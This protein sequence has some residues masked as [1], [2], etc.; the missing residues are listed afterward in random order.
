[1]R[2]I[3]SLVLALALLCSASLAL[4]EA[5]AFCSA[6]K[7]WSQATDLNANDYV[8]TFYASGKPVSR[9]TLRGADGIR[10]IKL[11]NAGQG[12]DAEFTETAIIQYSEKGITIQAQDKVIVVDVNSILNW[13]RC[14]SKYTPEM[15]KED[16]KLVRD[17]AVKAAM[18]LLQPTMTVNPETSALQLRIDVTEKEL[19]ERFP[20]FLDSLTADEA[21]VNALLM[22]YSGLVCS[23]FPSCPLTLD[24]LKALWQ[25]Y[26]ENPDWVMPAIRL[27]AD[28]AV[29]PASE[30]GKL[31]IGL[32]GNLSVT[33][34]QIS[35]SMEYLPGKNLGY[36]LSGNVN[37]TVK[38]KP[39]DVDLFAQKKDNQ[40]QA[41]L[42]VLGTEQVIYGVDANWTESS[43]SVTMSQQIGTQRKY[44][45]L[46]GYYDKA[47]GDLNGTVTYSAYDDA[48]P[49]EEAVYMDLVQLTATVQ[50]QGIMGTAIFPQNRSVRFTLTNGKLYYRGQFLYTDETGNTQVDAW[51]F[52]QGNKT[53]RYRVEALKDAKRYLISGTASRDHFDLTAAPVLQDPVLTLSVDHAPAEDHHGVTASLCLA[54]PGKSINFSG[55][56]KVDAQKCPIFVDA[57]LTTEGNNNIFPSGVYKLSYV[58]GQLTYIDNSNFYE[59]IRTEDTQ[60]KL[61]YVLTRNKVSVM[62]SFAS[63]LNAEEG[64]K[65]CLFLGEKETPDYAITMEAVP[66]EAPVREVVET[67]TVI[68]RFEGEYTAD[69]QVVGTLTETEPVPAPEP[70][71]VV[72]I[73]PIETENAQ[74]IDARTLIRLLTFRGSPMEVLAPMQGVM[75]SVQNNMIPMP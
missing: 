7:E 24:E 15:M 57:V 34:D 71:P 23:V 19:K 75:E 35:F 40:M 60:E 28:M 47:E 41:T 22:R 17:L 38:G 63:T 73:V 6:V 32:A 4:A 64:L 66:Y 10:E 54:Q 48:H 45:S 59:L 1:M 8:T 21:S 33:G 5:P 67:P 3:L 49:E 26:S 36:A 37:G 74:I 68:G 44:V 20:A 72:K 29:L 42:S 58:P 30:A 27:E 11:E 69:G 31:Q 12:E 61:A 18:T 55:E 25:K 9:S 43:Q 46:N 13:I 65:A 52:P 53:W 70:E 39:V 16:K 56:M 62:G 51:V 14:N 50:D 2:K